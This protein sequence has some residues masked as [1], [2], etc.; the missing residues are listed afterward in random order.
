M[1][2]TLKSLAMANVLGSQVINH[3]RGRLNID[4]F[5]IQR[6][7]AN[8]IRSTSFLSVTKSTFKQFSNTAVVLDS[9][10][11]QSR[12]FSSF[13]EDVNSTFVKCNFVSCA[14]RCIISRKSYDKCRIMNCVFRDCIDERVG[15]PD[16][17]GGGVLYATNTYVMVAKCE[18]TNCSSTGY[19][20]VLYIK[21]KE[22]D[23][24][25]CNFV[26][27]HR[28]NRNYDSA[29]FTVAETS[30]IENVN[31][32]ECTSKGNAGFSIEYNTPESMFKYYTA[33]SL[34][35][36]AALTNRI[37]NAIQYGNIINCTATHGLIRS[38]KKNTYISHYY[39]ADN[40]RSPIV[41]RYVTFLTAM[42]DCIFQDAD[43]KPVEKH[44][45]IVGPFHVNNRSHTI[46]VDPNPP[47]RK[48]KTNEFRGQIK[49]GHP[50]AALIC[51]VIS[52]I[53]LYFVAR[54]YGVIDY[55]FTSISFNGEQE[56]DYIKKKMEERKTKYN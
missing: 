23:I 32:S 35:G 37:F 53:G 43:E 6:S 11:Y 9:D 41:S 39:F 17:R 2:I 47:T 52:I 7:S 24:T 33:H 42:N 38:D 51:S 13:V 12:D 56:I 18:F 26:M 50:F 22:I 31:C 45:A 44:L 54:K 15:D 1:N 28:D 16:E 14:L 10:M 40:H 27:C 3:R 48:L 34:N 5:F 20:Q 36:Q 25:N 19:G 29:A 55:I 4:N 21:S 46:F 8:F 30:V 49:K